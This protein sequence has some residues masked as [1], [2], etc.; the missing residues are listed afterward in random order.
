[1]A[2]ANCAITADTPGDPKPSSYSLQPVTPASVL[3][4]TKW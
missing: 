1:M 4:F 3:T 2:P